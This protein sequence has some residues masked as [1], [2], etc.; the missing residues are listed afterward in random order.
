[1]L[2][3]KWQLSMLLLLILTASASAQSTSDLTSYSAGKISSQQLNDKSIIKPILLAKMSPSSKAMPASLELKGKISFTPVFEN[4]YFQILTDEFNYQQN[5][6]LQL[7]ELPVF[8]IELISINGTLFPKIRGTV[9]TPHPHWDYVIEPGKVWREGSDKSINR[10][11]LPFAL[12]EKNANCLHNGLITFLFDDKGKI[13]NG[14]Y[15][16]SSE[17]CTYLQFDASGYL[18]TNL[19]ADTSLAG[20]TI[21]QQADVYQKSVNSVTEL[22]ALKEQFA[23][24]D[25]EALAGKSDNN[26]NA[27]SVAG[28]II[29]GNHFQAPCM[30]RHGRHPLCQ[31]LT[32]PSYSLAKSMFASLT[33]HALR[34]RF[35]DIDSLQVT[36][37]VEQ[38][39]SKEWHGVS[40]SNLL[41]MNTGLYDSESYSDDEFSEKMEGFFDASSHQQKITQACSF[42]NKKQ[43][44]GE[45]F[46]YHTSD[47]YI[48]GTVLNKFYKR[49]HEPS[50]DLF[51]DFVVEQLFKPLALSPTTWTTR[52]SLGDIGQPFTGY[53]LN[54][55]PADI[56]A[57][58]D[59]A[60]AKPA[61]T[62]SA[63]KAW[64]HILA[65]KAQL[66][67]ETHPA[68]FA[69]NFA[70]AQGFWFQD[71]AEVL[72]CAKPTW[73][74]F[75]SGYGGI[76]VAFLPKQIT[77]YVFADNHNHQWA[78]ALVAID[79]IIPLCASD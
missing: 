59:A 8:D 62:L 46:I 21:S 67:N 61:N 71:I 12:Q 77:Y 41:N 2:N 68:I 40:T 36:D 57:L 66:T 15:Q 32:L 45:R 18:A 25:L 4:A 23:N 43:S 5:S 50:Q 70:Y 49:H 16:I 17:T 65:T 69:P 56:A 9:T 35:P 19:I 76:T 6:Q 47:T 79:A 74:P 34:Q 29:A 31:S 60:Y 24:A 51:Y 7:S 72:N 55:L 42:F 30:T 53:G 20:N 22:Q 39:N 37:W 10:A 64:Q 28:I 54:L 63:H 27:I 58:A 75:M 33:L 78:Q 11:L 13:S 73:V 1:M 14:F 44:P 3:S 52:R 26:S 48:L 38:C